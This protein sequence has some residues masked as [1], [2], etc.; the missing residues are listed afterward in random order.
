MTASIRCP[1]LQ[2][3]QMT[4][5][6]Q[7]TGDNFPWEQPCF[8]WGV[9]AFPSD[10]ISSAKSGADRVLLQTDALDSNL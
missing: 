2:V 1:P 10:S 3:A 5:G 7:T 8:G 4:G 6:I 9:A